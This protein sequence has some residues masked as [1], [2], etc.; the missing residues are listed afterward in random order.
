MPK[1]T[2]TNKHG[3]PVYSFNTPRDDCFW[4][5]CGRVVTTYPVTRLCDTHAERI[6]ASVSERHAYDAALERAAQERRTQWLDEL[7]ANRPDKPKPESKPEPERDPVVYYVQIMSHIKIGWTG[8]L[9]QRMRQF[10]PNSQL[11]A[12]HPGSRKD[13]AAIHKR[14]A[15]IRSH[16]RE[17]YPL[18]PQLLEHIRNVV[19]EHGE[20]QAVDFGAKPVEVPMPHRWTGTPQL[21]ARSKGTGIRL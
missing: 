3:V 14:F 4:P 8:N 12:V 15:H 10:P 13:E 17:W 2:R 7:V 16:G 19:R 18:V 20:P 9:E 11:L 21:R 6:A 1:A 5:G